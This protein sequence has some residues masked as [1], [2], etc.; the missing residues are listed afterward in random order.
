VKTAPILETV[1]GYIDIGANLTHKSLLTDIENILARS[2]EANVKTIIVT[3]TTLEESNKALELCRQFPDQLLCTAGV[4][5]HHADEWN[6]NAAL[7]L[8]ALAQF[9]QVRAIGETG[10]DFNRDF[11]PRECQINAFEGQLNLAK[12]TGLPIFSHQRD[13]HEVF[14]TTLKEH[15]SD[16]NAVVVHCFT[17][18]ESAL[19][20]Y[21]D[22]DCYIGITGWLCDE[23][24]GLDLQKIVRYIPE[25][26]I[27]I[28]TD[29]P[30]LLPRNMPKLSK[31]RINEPCHLPH[32]L[33]TLAECRNSNQSSLMQSCY[34]NTLRFFDIKQA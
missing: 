8:E 23:R 26:R 20:D 29:A 33:K 10:L 13:A 2:I 9:P 14:L 30:Y 7:T 17:D 5:P 15:R 31:K 3:G 24:R 4:H 12:K 32:I 11:S 1:P 25:N 19:R 6:S 22:M 27:M 18:N 28:E 21:L 16:L 34:A